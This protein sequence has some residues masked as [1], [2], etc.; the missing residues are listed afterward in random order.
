MKCVSSSDDDV[1]ELP[2][3]AVV[4]ILWEE[5]RE[6]LTTATRVVERAVRA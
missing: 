4:E 3:V 1:F 6:A 2:G 5:H